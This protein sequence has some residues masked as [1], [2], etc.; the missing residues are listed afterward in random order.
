MFHSVN[1]R[2]RAKKLAD[3]CFKLNVEDNQR[4]IM[5]EKA[6][7]IWLVQSKNMEK[8]VFYAPRGSGIMYGV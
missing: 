7:Q 1:H 5:R 2:G 3:I 4:S 8:E 6:C